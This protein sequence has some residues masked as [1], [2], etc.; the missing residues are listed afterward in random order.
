VTTHVQRTF[1]LATLGCKVNWCD[2]GLIAAAAAA[3]GW[4][5]VAHPGDAAVCVVNTCTVTAH[6]DASAR[7][8]INQTRREQPSAPLLVAGCMAR[9]QHDTLAALAGV[10]QVVE[11]IEPAAVIAAMEAASKQYTPPP[12]ATVCRPEHEP[13][14]SRRP[15]ERTRAFVKIQD[16]CSQQC[17]Y[18]V[19]PQA[20]GVPRSVP[21]ATVLDEVTRAGSEGFREVVL[22]GVHL[23]AY[24]DGTN[25]LPDLLEAVARLGAVPRIRLSSIEATAVNTALLDVFTTHASLMPH[26]HIPLQSGSDRVLSLMRRTVTTEAFVDAVRRFRAACNL[27]TVTTD[28]IVGFPG[29]SDDDFTATRR[30]VTEIEFGKVHVFRFSPRPGT[31]AA[32]MRAQF[33]PVSIARARDEQLIETAHAA[34]A[35]C[36]VRFTGVPLSVLIEHRRRGCFEGYSENYLRIRTTLPGLRPNESVRLAV[37]GAT[38]TFAPVR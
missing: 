11:S 8:L 30:L 35:R 10:D 26:L 15:A 29:E 31:A 22:T 14:A 18:C 7:K 3:A 12:D 13:S 28:I 19:V 33:V 9:V 36:R 20:R 6:A 24:D 27:A 37:D 25:R 1:Y 16:G 32:A 17:A 2:S 34:A 23:A 4:R 5:R 21:L 38:T